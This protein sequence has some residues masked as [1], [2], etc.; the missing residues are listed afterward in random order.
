MA[1]PAFDTNEAVKNLR[2]AGQSQKEAEAVV[3]TMGHALNHVATKDFVHNEV[4]A[5]GHELRQEMRELRAEIVE[6]QRDFAV[7]I[8]TTIAGSMTALTAIFALIV[9]VI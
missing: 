3:E 4:T 7:K 9:K 1:A 6:S 2:A 8:L 5:L